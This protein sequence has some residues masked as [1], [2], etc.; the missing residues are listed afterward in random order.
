MVNRIRFE[1]D[2]KGHGVIIFS[3]ADN[4]GG[5]MRYFS[6]ARKLNFN[7]SIVGEIKNTVLTRPRST[8]KYTFHHG[9]CVTA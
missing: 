6:H 3:Q 8:A 4:A 2:I 1:T 7:F 5:A 9:L